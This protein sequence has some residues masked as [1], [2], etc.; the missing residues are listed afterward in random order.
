MLRTHQELPLEVTNLPLLAVVTSLLLQAVTNQPHQAVTNLPH[1]I[2]VKDEEG[3][4]YKISFLTV[5]HQ[6]AQ[7]LVEFFQI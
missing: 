1:R 6:L 4:D 3:G 2:A 5:Y 7:Q